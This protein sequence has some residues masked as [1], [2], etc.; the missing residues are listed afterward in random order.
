M[1]KI[2]RAGE[3]QGISGH[4]T[5]KENNLV[6]NL[7]TKLARQTVPNMQ[8][9][10]RQVFR[11]LA[12]FAPESDAV[13]NCFEKTFFFKT[14]VDFNIVGTPSPLQPKIRQKQDDFNIH[15]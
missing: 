1:K 13:Q 10:Q 3:K 4:Q 12:L 15:Y 7:A 11:R 9:G 14:D 5:A 6:Q 8:R 2:E